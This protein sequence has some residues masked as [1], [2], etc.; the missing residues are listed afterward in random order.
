MENNLY[1]TCDRESGNIIESFQTL[2]KAKNAIID[3]EK[4]DKKDECF[5]ENFYD[6]V[7][8]NRNS[9]L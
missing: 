4:E 1:F 8:E 6:V 9:L 2:E 3:Y 5:T 7:D